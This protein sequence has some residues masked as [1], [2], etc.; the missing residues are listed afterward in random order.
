MSLLYW[1]FVDTVIGFK[2][3]TSFFGFNE[4]SLSCYI[5]LEYIFIWESLGSF[6]C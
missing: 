5:S 4:F 6:P 1:G 2:D 3:L